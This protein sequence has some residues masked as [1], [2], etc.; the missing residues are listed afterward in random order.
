M[1]EKARV[2]PLPNVKTY[3][4]EDI[5]TDLDECNRISYE[6]TIDDF[7]TSHVNPIRIKKLA[8]G[9]DNYLSYKR[10]HKER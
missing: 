1:T 4:Y 7:S 5:E 3:T 2:K 8:R 9:V 6:I 10:T